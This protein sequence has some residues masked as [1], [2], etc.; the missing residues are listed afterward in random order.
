MP[1]SVVSRPRTPTDAA[2]GSAGPR[3]FARG[4]ANVATLVIC[5]VGAV[6]IAGGYW[7]QKERSDRL[8]MEEQIVYAGNEITDAIASYYGAS[9]GKVRELPREW[10]DLLDDN[11]TGQH[12]QHLRSL[13]LDPMTGHRDW[14]PMRDRDGRIVGV[15]SASSQRSLGLPAF[16][17]ARVDGE[18]YSDWLFT[19]DPPARLR[20]ED[21]MATAPTPPVRLE[22]ARTLAAAAPRERTSATRSAASVPG[23][24]RAATGSTAASA[25]RMPSANAP[26]DAY[27]RVAAS[28][29]TAAG[30]GPDAAAP[31]G[32]RDLPATVPAAVDAATV[33]RRDPQ[34]DDA[35]PPVSRDRVA[36]AVPNAHPRSGA[37]DSRAVPRPD[38]PAPP[39]TAAVR[40]SSATQPPPATG[41]DYADAAATPADMK[42]RLAKVPPPEDK[43]PAQ[44]LETLLGKVDARTK[45]LDALPPLVSRSAPQIAANENA[46]DAAAR[47]A[48]LDPLHFTVKFVF[49]GVSL[50][51]N[52]RALVANLA[53]DAAGSDHLELL[54]QADGSGPEWINQ[55]IAMA[56]AESVRYALV[57]AGVSPDTI[58]VRPA[59]IHRDA[60]SPAEQADA[61]R[62][63]I[64]LFIKNGKPGPRS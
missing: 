1:D 41:S 9:P 2:S 51:P 63:D 5:A 57:R 46:L 60:L 29:R 52:G 23:D 32:T 31:Q 3:P 35:G 34:R 44:R 25:A 61:R 39:D 13:P 14:V 54:G 38:D 16:A 50:G 45:P 17:S 58:R 48:G 42:L 56:R 19:F 62:V 4:Q 40:E 12:T 18:H 47:S 7:Y 26:S 49:E 55:R 33:G 21:G 11:R 53:N 8:R 15:H 36:A 10:A 30:A 27:N 24:R 6:T 64:D 43:Y 28:A 22:E 20:R 59:I 37:V